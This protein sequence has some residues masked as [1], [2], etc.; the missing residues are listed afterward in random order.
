M[1]QIINTNC[2]PI[3]QSIDLD[4]PNGATINPRAEFAHRHR[5][6]NLVQKSLAQTQQSGESKKKHAA[7]SSS[8]LYWI[9]FIS[10]I[11]ATLTVIL[12][13]IV[14]YA[15][16]EFARA[17]HTL[18]TDER[19]ILIN[20][21][22]IIA[23]ANVIR[24]PSQ[25][26]MTQAKRLELYFHWPT[27]EGYS[28]KLKFAFNNIEKAS[29]VIFITLAPRFSGL[30]MTGRVKPI[31]QKFYVS[32]A[33][34]MHNGLERYELDSDAGFI[35]EYLMVQKNSSRPFSARCVKFVPDG[36][37]PY[38]IRDILIGNDLALTYRF[39]INLIANWFELDQS[40][41]NRFRAMI[42]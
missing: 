10:L 41:R 17:G 1:Q 19:R 2:G 30:D 8:G 12:N 21:D 11:I 35:N 16:A 28:Q 7:F 36:P 24:Y 27:M 25:R 29:D 39:H 18:K 34:D 9:V 38:C 33:I 20:S 23:P 40:I 31:Y 22:L 13:F 4:H 37:V 26:K 3:L 5:L 15:G 32:S 14:G 6:P 42:K